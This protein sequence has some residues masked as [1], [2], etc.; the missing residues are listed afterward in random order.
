M[1]YSSLFK[2]L[3]E[4]VGVPTY[5]VEGYTRQN[6]QLGNLTHQWCMAEIDGK[7]YFFD[8]TWDAGYVKAGK[9]FIPKPDIRFFKKTP[10]EQIKDHMPFDPMWQFL[11]QT[12]SFPNFDKGKVSLPDTHESTI[13]WADTLHEYMKQDSLH[14]WLSTFQR[15][16]RNGSY[17]NM[18]KEELQYLQQNINI[19]I[20]NLAI[21][22]FNLAQ[23]DFN[24][25]I[26]LLNSFIAYRNNK[27]KPKQ[28]ESSVRKMVDEAEDTLKKSITE[29]QGILSSNEE[30]TAYTAKLRGQQ[31]AVLKEINTQKAFINKYY[32]TKKIFR[33]AL[34]HKYT[35]FGIPLN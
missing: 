10:Q 31:E 12:V 11:P 24:Q 14:Q 25:S 29:L 4:Q 8:P 6:G 34:F 3:A 16:K 9:T 21:R 18:V 15:I 28:E 22:Q 26:N 13:L 33:K 5:C 7:Q 20:N 35:W 2:T 32:S 23:Q 17:N 19:S 30:V 1:H 27:F